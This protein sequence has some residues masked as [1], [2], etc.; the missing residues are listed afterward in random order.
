MA[1]DGFRGIV[2]GDG[3]VFLYSFRSKKKKKKQGIMETEFTAAIMRPGDT[4]STWT[5]MEKTPDIIVARGDAM[6][7]DGKVLVWADDSLWCFLL[8]TNGGDG[9]LAS[10]RWRWN[11]AEDED[12]SK[13]QGEILWASVLMKKKHRYYDHDKQPWTLR[14]TV[15]ALQKEPWRWVLVKGDAHHSLRQVG[16]RILFL[17]SPASFSA[18]HLG[19]NSAYFAFKGGVYRACQV[20]ALW[21]DVLRCMCGVAPPQAFHCSG[22]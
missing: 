13:S 6:Y 1:M 2:Y 15:R 8:Q 18:Y 16:N 19:D 20:V 7:H 12:D 4:T 9:I 14:V 17:G 3:T 21:M 22:A 11:V 10:S 5:V